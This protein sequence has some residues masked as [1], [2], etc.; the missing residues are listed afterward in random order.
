MS[1]DVWKRNEIESPCV[2]LCA[3]HPKAKICTGCHRSLDEIGNWSRMTPEARREVMA[4]LPN[5]ASL[6]KQRRG[7]RSARM[8][9]Q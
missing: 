4:D 2:K 5:R 9:G 8:R 1:D 3:I 7:G 6:L